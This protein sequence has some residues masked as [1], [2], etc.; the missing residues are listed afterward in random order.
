MDSPTLRSL[1]CLPYL[2]ILAVRLCLSLNVKEALLMQSNEPCEHTVSGNR[3][4]CCTNV[5][6]IAF[7][8]AVNDLQGH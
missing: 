3:V 8:N 1:W 4:K 5:R 2:Q 6:R 7:E